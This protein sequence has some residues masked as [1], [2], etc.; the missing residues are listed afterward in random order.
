MALKGSGS[1]CDP[2]GARRADARSEPGDRH[3]RAERAA[4]GRIDARGGE[5]GRHAALEP[6]QRTARIVEGGGEDAG[7]PRREQQDVAEREP[8][9]FVLGGHDRRDRGHIL[10]RAAAEEGERDVQRVGRDGP[11]D[12]LVGRGAERR[13]GRRGR[14]RG[15]RARRRGEGAARRV[16]WRPPPRAAGGAAAWAAAPARSQRGARGRLDRAAD[17]VDSPVMRAAGAPSACGGRRWWCGRGRR[18]GRPAGARCAPRRRWRR[19]RR[20]RR[21]RPASRPSRRPGRR[22]R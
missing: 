17:E 3:V 15:G 1:R 12:V 19:T 20:C 18:R 14:R 11:P 8:R 4:L 21:C 22:C 2:G 13:R 10:R 16:A 7:A 5:R 9:R 6:A